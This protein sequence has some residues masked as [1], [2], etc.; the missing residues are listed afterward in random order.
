MG[1]FSYTRAKRL[2]PFRRDQRLC[3]PLHLRLAHG[4][5]RQRRAVDA[6]CHYDLP[7]GPNIGQLV[8]RFHVVD[9]LGI[10]AAR[11]TLD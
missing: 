3:G 10:I 6:F 7:G 2:P 11:Q 8:H 4:R 5:H 1:I 9:E